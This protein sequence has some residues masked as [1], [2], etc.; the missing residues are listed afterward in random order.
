[1]IPIALDPHFASLAVAGNGALTLRR[2]RALRDAGADHAL[3]FAD[4]PAIGLEDD[5]A[6]IA[7]TAFRRH[8]PGSADFAT[9][10]VLWIVDLPQDRAEALAR[11]ARA[12]G[13][14][15]NVEDCPPFCD[16][17]SV[18]ELRRGDLLITVSTGGKAA[19]LAS[20]IREALQ[21][22]FGPEWADRVSNIAERRAGWRRE[23]V[24]MAEARRRI[25]DHVRT[26][27]WL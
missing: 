16:F 14:L 3:L 15:V 22:R 12:S 6:E 13:I 27:G 7:G 24:P 19:G 2:Y 26:E 25:E 11:E 20:V 21:T 17:H 10:H 5:F 23:G 8:L 1:M 9:L 4:A 18:A